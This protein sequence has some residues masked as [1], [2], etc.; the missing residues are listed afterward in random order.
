MGISWDAGEGGWERGTM[1]TTA[2]ERWAS[3]GLGAGILAAW[4]EIA[5]LGQTLR[6]ARTGGQEK[7]EMGGDV[8]NFR[9]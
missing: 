5:T 8:G 9:K 2:G 1:W 4:P 3:H 6:A 7:G